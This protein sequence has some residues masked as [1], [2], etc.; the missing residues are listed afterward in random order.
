M[1]RGDFA[2]AAS[3]FNQALRL[4]PDF[5]PARV[6]GAQASQLTSA[7]TSTTN[8]LAQRAAAASGRL[9]AP[10]DVVL[11]ATPV[12]QTLNNVDQGVN[13]TPTTATIDLGASA[14]SGTGAT[15]QN[16]DPVQESSGSDDVTKTSTAK[17]VI[18]IKRPGTED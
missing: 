8:D 9:T 12:A 2:A 1:D 7:S 3:F 17:I 15:Q 6:Q 13:P 5:E 10:P 18:Q 11:P 16:R 4:D 14:G